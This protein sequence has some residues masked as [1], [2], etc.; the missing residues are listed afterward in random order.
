GDPWQ[1]AALFVGH[2]SA[3]LGSALL[4]ECGYA[5]NE[6]ERKDGTNEPR[7]HLWPPHVVSMQRT[8]RA[9]G[10]EAGRI[11][12]LAGPQSNEFRGVNGLAPPQRWSVIGR[13]DEKDWFRELGEV[14]V[15]SPQPARTFEADQPAVLDN[16]P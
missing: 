2:A 8:T 13:L 3:D 10:D 5:D 1:H 15:D 14:G 7:S 9:D 11:K 6:K 4:R 16:L 12:Q